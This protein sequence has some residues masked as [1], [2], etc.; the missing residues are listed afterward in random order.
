MSLK[1]ASKAV[2]LNKKKWR[3]IATIKGGKD[4]KKIVYLNDDIFEKGEK[5]TSLHLDDD[6]VF[7][8][9]PNFGGVN[10]LYVTGPSGSGKSY[11]CSD[12]ISKYLKKRGNKDIPIYIFSG[13]D[14][15][16]ILD[17]K[18][19]DNIIRVPIDAELITDPIH[20]SD[21]K[22]SIVLMDDVDSIQ[23][24]KLRNTVLAL[25]RNLLETCRHYDIA[26]IC[27][28]HLISNYSKT[29]TLLNES[30]SVTV[31]P[32]FSGGT[33][34]IKKFLIGYCGFSK[35]QIKKF[36]GLRS[37]GITLTRGL[38]QYV[39]GEKDIYLSYEEDD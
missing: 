33:C 30:T 29:R 5:N 11:Y 21:L 18:F 9:L 34:Q 1:I 7:E 22:D 23:N 24:V 10:R 37:R 20:P 35:D 16:P 32:R 8:A 19:E 6:G 17:D 27:T 15:D 13:V 3:P 28:S 38:C 25:R 2:K 36:L 26:L 4:H 12:W 14:Y 31:F 39:Q